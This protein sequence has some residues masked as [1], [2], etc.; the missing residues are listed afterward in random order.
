MTHRV[1]GSIL[2]PLL[3]EQCVILHVRPDLHNRLDVGRKGHEINLSSL[4]QLR[5]GR[6]DGG[7]LQIDD[8]RLLLTFLVEQI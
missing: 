1:A 2:E 6:C 5:A 8:L 4:L 3:D 7:V